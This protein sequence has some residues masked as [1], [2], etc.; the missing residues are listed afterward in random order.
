MPHH[1]IFSNTGEGSPKSQ[2]RNAICPRGRIPNGI[3]SRRSL[4]VAEFA[5]QNTKRNM[6][7]R[8]RA[9]DSSDEDSDSGKQ[10]PA[11]PRLLKWLK[12]PKVS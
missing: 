5:A 6:P 8:K 12:T 1:E 3:Y 2:F 9:I 7:F 11:T 10:T 4:D